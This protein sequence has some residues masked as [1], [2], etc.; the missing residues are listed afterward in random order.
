MKDTANALAQLTELEVTAGWTLKK[1]EQNFMTDPKYDRDNWW[2]DLWGDVQKLPPGAMRDA[3]TT[4]LEPHLSNRPNNIHKCCATLKL[5]TANVHTL[6][7]QL[8]L[9]AHKDTEVTNGGVFTSA[10]MSRADIVFQGSAGS[11]LKIER[12]GRATGAQS[13]EFFLHLE[14]ERQDRREEQKRLAE[15]DRTPELLSMRTLKTSG[16]VV[17]FH[18]VQHYMDH[19]FEI[20]KIL[21]IGIAPGLTDRGIHGAVI[22]DILNHVN[23]RFPFN[24]FMD[25]WIPDD[26]TMPSIIA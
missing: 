12:Q 1:Y 15:V 26:T 22:G 19:Q 11:V 25:Q 5:L 24:N 18:I 14:Q 10:E 17:A 21:R 20:A 3:L 9:F 2:T 23:K 13:H 4:L 7:E 8:K 6:V 16:Q